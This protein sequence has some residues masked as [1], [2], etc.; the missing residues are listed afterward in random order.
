MK[1]SPEQ[2]VRANIRDLTP[3][4]SARQDHAAGILLDANENSFGSVVSINGVS[5]NRYPDPNQIRLRKAFAALNGVG[6]DWIFAGVGSDEIIDLLIRLFCTP[7][8]DSVLII[9]PTYGM[10]GVSAAINEVGLMSSLLTRDFQIDLQDVL[11]KASKAKIIFC[12]SPN[13]PTANL[14]R[15]ADIR[16]LCEQTEAMVVVDEAYI[17]FAGGSSVAAFSRD[18]RNLIVLRTLSKAWGLAAIRLGYCIADPAVIT[19][20][21]KIKP[22]YNIN[23]LTSNAALK[24]LAL[25]SEMR[26]TVRKILRERDRLAAGLKAIS[27]VV[28]VYDSDANF[29]LVRCRNA[30]GLRDRLAAKGII[31][32]DRSADPLLDN[33]LRVTVGTPQQNDALLTA[34]TEMES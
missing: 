30:R 9:E 16:T 29:L 34:I 13:N 5:L 1:T 33:C 15:A 26:E 10:Y 27:S 8:K 22:P 19:Y 12:C 18:T 17:D 20:L 25:E 32:R 3:Y 21:M 2:L 31:L 7:A 14:L 11:S 28:S 23:T 24:A 6:E 4:R